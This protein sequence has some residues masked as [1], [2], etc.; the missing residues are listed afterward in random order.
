MA[1]INILTWFT[2]AEAFQ[3]DL[4][5]LWASIII[6]SILVFLPMVYLVAFLLWYCTKRYHEGFSVKVKKCRD[7]MRKR[8]CSAG[9]AEEELSPIPQ[10]SSTTER[11]EFYT[12][13]EN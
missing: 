9:A 6:E 3:I 7:N 12:V 2:V 8:L 5:S 10:L 13:L 11:R 1:L 4:A